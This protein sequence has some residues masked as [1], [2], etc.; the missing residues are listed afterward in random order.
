MPQPFTAT[1]EGFI[2]AADDGRLVEYPAETLVTY[3]KILAE[4]SIGKDTLHA[5]YVAS[6]N[7]ATD[8]YM[9]K[10]S[11]KSDECEPSRSWEH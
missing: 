1:P 11:A 3:I 10:R 9:N 8:A 4:L 7:V 2:E 6:I 5:D